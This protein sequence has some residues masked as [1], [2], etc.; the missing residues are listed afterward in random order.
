MMTGSMSAMAAQ[1][2]SI[3][4]AREA[5]F[6]VSTD[7]PTTST[8]A[9]AAV[10]ARAVGAAPRAN[11]PPATGYHRHGPPTSPGRSVSLIS[12]SMKLNRLPESGAAGCDA[13]VCSDTTSTARY[14]TIRTR[15]SS[16]AR[17]NRV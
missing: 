6:L 3:A 10:Q 15:Y 16:H 1:P 14:V 8:T 13:D 11:E 12:D 2:A 5:I 9:S 4:H 7:A 17:Q